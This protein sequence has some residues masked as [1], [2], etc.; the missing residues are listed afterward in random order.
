MA[1]HPSSVLA[2]LQAVHFGPD[3]SKLHTFHASAGGAGKT[4]RHEDTPETNA[5]DS[6]QHEVHEE[7]G[8]SDEESVTSMNSRH[9]RKRKRDQMQRCN[10]CDQR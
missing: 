2:V 9:A 7:I 3:E 1:S 6:D 5:R 10:V 4:E 8:Y